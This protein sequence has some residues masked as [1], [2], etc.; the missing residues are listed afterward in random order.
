MPLARFKKREKCIRTSDNFRRVT[1]LLKVIVIFFGCMELGNEKDSTKKKKKKRGVFRN[2]V[3][4]ARFK[5]HEKYTRKSDNFRRVAD[6][7]KVILHHGYF[8]RFFK[9]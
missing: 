1:G 9:L 8:S 4:L 7:L 6:L 2:L 3:P 5:K